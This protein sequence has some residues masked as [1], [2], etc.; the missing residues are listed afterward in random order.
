[1]CALDVGPRFKSGA[2]CCDQERIR[3]LL[4]QSHRTLHS[5][6][7]ERAH[8][9]RAQALLLTGSTARGTRTLISDLDYLDRSAGASGSG[10]VKQGLGAE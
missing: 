2:R 10:A 4:P 1:M 3:E 5:V 6:L 9:S 8:E 7:V